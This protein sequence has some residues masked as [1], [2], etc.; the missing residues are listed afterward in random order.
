MLHVSIPKSSSNNTKINFTSDQKFVQVMPPYYSELSLIFF[1]KIY[2]HLVILYHVQLLSKNLKIKLY[3]TI[4]LSC[5][6]WVWSLVADIE[7]G[8]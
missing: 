3:R 8:T 1:Q 5:F 7:G 2:S 4:I 6:V